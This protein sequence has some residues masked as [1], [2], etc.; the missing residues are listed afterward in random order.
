MSDLF[1]S[2]KD[3]LFGPVSDGFRITPNANSFF[4]YTTRKLW[5][6]SAGNVEVELASTNRDANTVLTFYNVPAGTMLDVRAVRCLQG[7]TTATN[8][9]GLY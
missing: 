9:L 1:H 6:G 3:Q 7:N 4:A 8:L 5:V 2:Q